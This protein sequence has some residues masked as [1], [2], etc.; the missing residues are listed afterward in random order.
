MRH[1]RWFSRLP[2]VALFLVLGPA[3][4]ASSTW[5]V[6]QVNGSDKNNCKSPQHACKTIGHAISLASSGDSIMIAAAT[7]RENLT[8]NFSLELI[9]AGARTTIVNGRGA[10]TVF[11]AP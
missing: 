3:A 6:N 7:Y 5:Y 11:Y 2:F 10:N 1:G 8:L 9:G 4:L